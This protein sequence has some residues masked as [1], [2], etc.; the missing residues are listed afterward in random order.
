MVR[1]SKILNN[2]KYLEIILRVAFSRPQN[3]PYKSFFQNS[4]LFFHH[5]F[6]NNSCHFT[7]VY[8]FTVC[9][10]VFKQLHHRKYCEKSF[11]SLKVVSAIFFLVYVL[12]LKE[13][14]GFFRFAF[15]TTFWFAKN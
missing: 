6:T 14:T 5:F 4:S 7:L 1:G 13:S 2:K 3:L 11:S 9:Y 10:I 12:C 8:E 15:S